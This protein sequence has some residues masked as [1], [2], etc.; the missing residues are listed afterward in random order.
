MKKLL[1]FTLLSPCLLAVEI[2]DIGSL[3]KFCPRGTE[4]EQYDN[5]ELPSSEVM[6][7]DQRNRGSLSLTFMH[8]FDNG[9]LLRTLNRQKD[10]SIFYDYDSNG[11]LKS[12]SLSLSNG[13]KIKCNY[14]YKGDTP[15]FKS[16]GTSE[17]TQKCL[18]E[19]VELQMATDFMTSF[20][21]SCDPNITHATCFNNST[22]TFSY[23]DDAVLE[24]YRIMKEVQALEDQEL[25][26]TRPS[27]TL[28]S[29]QSSQ[30]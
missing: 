11:K 3:K 14:Q 2:I 18:D 9:T 10:K 23:A 20:A 30:R 17:D 26:G 8:T 16:N 24:D 25:I 22:N 28:D 13:K 4:V 12:L 7:G 5:P 27:R 29:S 19:Y 21:K 15:L 1:F 6:C